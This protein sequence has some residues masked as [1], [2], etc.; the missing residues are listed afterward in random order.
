MHYVPKNNCINKEYENKE[1]KGG[2]V[3]FK[4][5]KMRSINMPEMIHLL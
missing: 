4:Y 3:V 1:L 2:Q 5:L